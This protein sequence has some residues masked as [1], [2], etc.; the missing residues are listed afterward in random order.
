MPQRKETVPATRFFSAHTPD[1]PRAEKAYAA[2]LAAGVPEEEVSVLARGV[3]VDRQLIVSSEVNA[4]RMARAVKPARAPGLLACR[5]AAGPLL[6][7]EGCWA[8]GPLFA[9]HRDRPGHAPGGELDRALLGAGMSMAAASLLEARLKR[10]GGVWFAMSAEPTVA[11]AARAR[12]GAI[13]GIEVG[14][15]QA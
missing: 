2:L 15:E 14:W 1:V 3:E 8:T 11:E 13:A 5:F 9:G 12:L 6:V 10:E 7:L 4:N